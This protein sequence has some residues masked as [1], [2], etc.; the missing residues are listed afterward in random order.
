MAK[1]KKAS[2]N[3]NAAVKRLK[4][5]GPGRLYLLYGPEEYLRERYLDALREQCVPGGE[6]FSCRRLN[7]QGLELGE[8]EEAVNAMPFLTER[9]I[10]EVGDYDLNKCRDAD[11]ERLKRIISDIPDWC[12]LVFAQSESNAPDGR[13]AAVK[14][15]KKAGTAIEFSEQDPAM[16]GAWVANRFKALGKG[17][18]RSDAEYLIFL[19]G[20]RMQGLIPEIEKAA[21]FASGGTVRRV[22]ID[23]T[24]N[25]VPEADVWA[26]TD[27]LAARRYDAAAATLSDLLGDKNNHPILLNAL[28]GQQMRR[29]YACKAGQ[30]AGRSRADVMELCDVRYD[31]IYEKLLGAVKPYSLEQ[32]GRMVSLCAEYDYRMKSTGADAGNLLR[33]LF[34][35][36]AAGDR[37]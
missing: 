9:T 1:A 8:L 33:E 26:M 36:L 7:G 23:A 25:R 21:A 20:T 24:A 10:V 31:F 16:L 28:L 27:Q 17:V 6:E 30:E 14:G 12:T 32:L 19:C 4:A 18:E 22:D 11:W 5:E 37:L 15:L 2:F 34:A 13:L 35:R 29:M 3:Y